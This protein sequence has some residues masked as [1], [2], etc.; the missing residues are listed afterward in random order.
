MRYIEFKIAE[1]RL[2]EQSEVYVI[3]DSHA[4]AMG[5][6]NN[7]AQDG[8]RLG[9]I[10]SQAQQVPDGATV[11][12]TGGHNDV[13]GGSGAQ[14][15]ASQVQSI[16]NSLESRGVTVNYILFPEGSSNPNQENMAP[17][18]S[19]I[20]SAVTVAQDLDGCSMQSDGIH[21]S[22]GSYR[23]IVGATNTTRSSRGS[24][25]TETDDAQGLT[26]GPPYPSED[27]QAVR[28]MQT[29]LE[30]LGYSVGSTGIDGKY[31][32]RTTRAVAAFKRDNNID[33]AAT[34]LSDDEL[35]ALASAEPVENPSPTG[36]S[37]FDS[38]VASGD[39]DFV[40]PGYPDGMSQADMEAIIR[41][42]AELRNIDP[43]VAV[44]I[45]RSE[46][47]GA[48]QSTVPRS[49]RG[50]LGGREAS[51][52]PYQLYIGG[53]L[54]NEYQRRTGRDLTQDNTEEGIENQIRFALDMAIEQ[55]WQPWYGRR[56]AGVGRTQGLENARQVRNWS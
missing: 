41:D 8:A 9:V 2:R 36:N 5:G 37:S 7:L 56:S 35:A 43:D 47:A 1:T 34:Q 13:A 53:G 45:F 54:G 46:G 10:A 40:P 48:Y 15:I 11:Y 31:G 25:D 44:A 20:S 51:F 32:P 16:I 4:R 42:E 52:G 14:Q 6:S 38:R 29:R 17:T 30:D 22:L 33:S 39:P 19:A 23:G 50:S 24:E 28:D 3:G 27:M 12:M 55:S 21:C 49:G 18:R 26:A